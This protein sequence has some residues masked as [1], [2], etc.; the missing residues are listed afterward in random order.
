MTNCKE[1]GFSPD[2]SWEIQRSIKVKVEGGCRNESGIASKTNLQHHS[3]LQLIGGNVVFLFD[4]IHV[5][6]VAL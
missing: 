5:Y 3:G 1:R 4:I 2:Y 6:A